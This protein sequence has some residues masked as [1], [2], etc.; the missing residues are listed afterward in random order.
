MRASSGEL[1]V[2]LE[3]LPAVEHGPEDVDA[4]SG[5]GEDGLVMAFALAPLAVPSVRAGRG[6]RT[7]SEGAA[8]GMA[9][10]AEGGLVEDA[11]EPLVAA[12][13]RLRKRTLPDWRRTGAMPAAA[14]SASAERKRA[15][16]PASAISS[17]VSTAPMPAGCG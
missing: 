4:S 6:R 5:E 13:G 9:E 2:L 12:V 15:R 3:G 17:A 16:L 8:V 10:G 1:E 7:S 11:L 14:A